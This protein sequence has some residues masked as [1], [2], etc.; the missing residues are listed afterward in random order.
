ME[1]QNQQ[2]ID[3]NKQSNQYTQWN[4]L[5][6]KS[7]INNRQLDFIK[8]ISISFLDSNNLPSI[9]MIQFGDIIQEKAL[10]FPIDSR[11]K[12]FQGIQKNKIIDLLWY[13]PLTQEK[14][15]LKCNLQ[16]FN[17]QEQN[18]QTQENE[19]Y[20]IFDDMEQIYQ[21]FWDNKIDKEDK[22]LFQ[23]PIPDSL[24]EERQVINKQLTDLDKY[25]SYDKKNLSDNFALLVAIPFEITHTKY[26]K[27]QV[28]ADSRKPKFESIFQPYKKCN[29]YLHQFNK[30]K[31]I[32]IINPV[33][34]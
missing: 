10:I 15:T 31:Q 26:P 21:N 2:K 9:E 27:P 30:E 17:K 16:I 24:T 25:N 7:I 19:N 1:A 33:N 14:Y 20:I 4:V 8:N 23:N 6:N 13:F 3:S 11:T 34:P 22:K 29:K 12:A 18:Q 32:W 28:I 5:L